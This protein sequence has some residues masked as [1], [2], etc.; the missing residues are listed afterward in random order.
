MDDKIIQVMPVSDLWAL[1]SLDE[2]FII[3]KVVCL[4]LDQGGYINAMVCTDD[5]ISI[6]SEASNF[7]RLFSGICY[8]QGERIYSK[9]D[10]LMMGID[11]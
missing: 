3:S 5:G 7:I 4:A 11:P 1:F 2:N 10:L 6:A 9:E 8:Y